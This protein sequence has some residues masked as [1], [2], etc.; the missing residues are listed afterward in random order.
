M[1]RHKKWHLFTK[2]LNVSQQVKSEVMAAL[3]FYT[4]NYTYYCQIQLPVSNET[5]RCTHV[6]HHQNAGKVFREVQS[7]EISKY[8]HISALTSPEV[9]KKLLAFK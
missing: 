2:L 8:D 3:V 6:Y 4:V 5:L 1:T 7:R 9:F